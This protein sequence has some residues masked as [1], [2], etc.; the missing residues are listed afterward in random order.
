MTADSNTNVKN[1]EIKLRI[2]QYVGKTFRDKNQ[3]QAKFRK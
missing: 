2:K 1:E 3:H